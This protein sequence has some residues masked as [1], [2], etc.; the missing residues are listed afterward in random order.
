MPLSINEAVTAGITKLRLAKWLNPADHIEIA[1]LKE[2]PDGGENQLG[3]WWS[4]WSPMNEEVNGRNPVKN[5]VVGPMG[6]G[7]LDDEV[8]TIYTS[9][10]QPTAAPSSVPQHR[11]AHRTTRRRA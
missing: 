10:R 11:V 9:P 3:P 1:I 5:L 6:L 4:L 8:W 2:R 7:D